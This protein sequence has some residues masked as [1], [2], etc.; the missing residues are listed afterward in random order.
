[1]MDIPKLDKCS[2]CCFRLIRVTMRLYSTLFSRQ[3]K[4]SLFIVLVLCLVTWLVLNAGEYYTVPYTR[5]GMLVLKY[6][7]ANITEQKLTQ[8]TTQSTTRGDDQLVN[9]MENGSKTDIQKD[10]KSFSNSALIN[11]DKNMKESY[12]PT[13]VSYDES[14]VVFFLGGGKSGS[15]TLATYL[16]HDPNDWK[17]WDPHGQFMDGGKEFCWSMARST[18]E[19]FWKHFKTHGSKTAVFALDACPRADAKTHYERMVNTFP[20]A[21]YLMLVRDPV[22]RFISH[23]NDMN[24]G[25]NRNIDALVKTQLSGNSL[26]VRLSMF[27]SIIQNAYSVLPKHKILIIPNPDMTKYP[28]ETINKVMK[29]IG[30]KPKNVTLVEANKRKD[31]TTYQIPSNTTISL[32][33]D[34][35]HSDWELFKKLSGLDI[36]T[37]YM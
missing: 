12:V 9:R 6:S 32:L 3:K 15:T 37:V 16:K 8:S 2:Y 30:A 14:K 4:K 5:P 36:E 35:F 11:H 21:S 23:M 22:D 7:F 13:K 29:H 18:K 25:Q 10:V 33:K 19:S 28:Q 31:R 24:D 17:Q 27:G 1:M 34:K 26:A 20:N